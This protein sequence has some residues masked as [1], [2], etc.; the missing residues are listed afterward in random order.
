MYP[1]TDVGGMEG[2]TELPE[3]EVARHG[4]RDEI[5]NHRQRGSPAY[6]ALTP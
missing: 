4:G 1:D 5:T 2:Y 3:R 6:V